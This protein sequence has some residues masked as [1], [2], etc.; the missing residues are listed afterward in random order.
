MMNEATEN[1]YRL[2]IPIP[3]PLRNVNMY[4]LREA[5]GK[6]WV[7][8]DTAMGTP[9]AREAL[10]EGLQEASLEI[11][12]LRAIVLTH[13][14]P[15]HVGLSAELQEQSGAPVYMH[16][17]DKAAL[18]LLWSNTMEQRFERVSGFFTKHGLPPTELWYAKVDPEVMRYVLRVPPPDMIS[19]VED[20][21]TLELIG[22]RY[23]VIWVP[24]HSDGQIVLFRERD[25]IFIAAD[26]VLPRITPNIGLYSEKDRPDPLG[27]YLASLA[28]IADLP[29]SLVLPGHGE[30]FPDLKKRTL[31]IVA[32][33]EERLNNILNM[34]AQRPQHA[35]DITTQLFGE[36]LKNGEARRMAAAEVL[37]HLEYLRFKGKV[38]QR[39]TKDGH[40]Q[41]AMV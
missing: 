9:D 19:T 37:S 25:G 8:I 24:G 11:K 40:I 29:A 41:Y 14:H 15:D 31:E 10:S 28:K 6:D 32:H 27:D 20:G 22:E 21:Q 30:P 1:I 16:P 12:H 4:A 18:G 34:L 3:F 33:H 17:I 38:D 23:R 26:H 5:Q 2:C 36:R 7:L 39:H 35:Y 13:H